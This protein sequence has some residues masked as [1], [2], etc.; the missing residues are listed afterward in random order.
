M[1]YMCTFLYEDK[2]AVQSQKFAILAEFGINLAPERRRCNE[3]GY[4]RG[5]HTNSRRLIRIWRS[6]GLIPS[7]NR[8]QGGGMSIFFFFLRK[9]GG[10]AKRENRDFG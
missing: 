1:I 5:F 2:V 4:P 3:I 7:R 9:Q 6:W 8:K 10:S